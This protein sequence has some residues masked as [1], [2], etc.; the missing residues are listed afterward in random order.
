[1]CKAYTPGKSDQ[2]LHARLARVEQVI[3]TALPQYWSAGNAAEANG[4]G[5]GRRSSTPGGDDDRG[6]QAD[7]EDGGGIYESGRW[8][9]ASASGIVA[10]PAM[11][12]K[13]RSPEYFR[14]QGMI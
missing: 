7:E 13:V 9:G 5:D 10:A 1:M 8:F 3:A 11:L 2:D 4:S 6:S 12:E 14:R